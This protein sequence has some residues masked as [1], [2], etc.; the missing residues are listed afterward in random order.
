[1]TSRDIAMICASDATLT[2]AR[3]GARVTL[4]QRLERAEQLL[5]DIADAPD[6]PRLAA[7]RMRVRDFLEGRG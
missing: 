2:A 6:L 7:V 1:M 3:I 4:T 5:N